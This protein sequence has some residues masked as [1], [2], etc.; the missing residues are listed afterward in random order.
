MDSIG[1]RLLEKPDA[2][3]W[4]VVPGIVIVDKK[5]KRKSAPLRIFLI[6]TATVL[7][8][9]GCDQ[10]NDLPG[11]EITPSVEGSTAQPGIETTPVGTGAIPIT[12]LGGNL[13]QGF[14]GG[15]YPGGSN[16]M[17]PQHAQAG[18]DRAGRVQP[19]TAAG[20]PS[21]DGKY[22]LLSI[23]MANAAEEFCGRTPT[24][25]QPWSFAGLAAQSSE[26]NHEQLVIVN[27]AIYGGSAAQWNAPA[28]KSYDRVRDEALAPLGL[29]ERQVQVV[30][31]KTANNEPGSKPSIPDPQSDAQFLMTELGDIIR[32]LR[33]RYPNLQQVFISSRI[34]GGYTS[35]E[36]NPEPYAYESGFA[37]KWVIE[38][39]IQQMVDG[40][41]GEA[42]GNLNYNRIAPWIAWGPYLWTDG[43]NPRSDGLVWQPGDVEPDSV[44]P[45]QSG[46]RKVGTM[47]FQ[48]FSSSP[49]TTPWFL[50]N[51]PTTQPPTPTPVPQASEP[52]PTSAEAPVESPTP[53]AVVV[54]PTPPAAT[55]NDQTP[56]PL[57][58]MGNGT[59]MGFPGGLYPGGNA[60]PLAHAQFGL[61]QANLIQP[62]DTAGNPSP[63][64]K[65]VLLAVGMSNAAREFGVP[66]RQQNHTFVGQVF[67]N[68]AVDMENL[69]LINGARSGQDAPDWEQPNAYNYNWV[70]DTQLVPNGLSENQVQVI[71]LKQ[72]N[73]DAGTRPSLPS[74]EADAYVFMERMGNILRSLKIRYP[75]LRQVFIS[76]RVYGGYSTDSQNP[77]PYAYESGFA[78]KWL[79][80]AQ[81][82]QMANGGAVINSHAGDLNYETAA[83]WIAWGPYMWANGTIPRSD[84]LVWVPGDFGP[85][86][87]HPFIE[88]QRKVAE[89]LLAFFESSPLTRC[90]FLAEG[91]C[92]L[93]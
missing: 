62:L 29:N 74:P 7:I 24:D 70:R 65:Y 45:S 43:L 4:E 61:E 2:D 52:E 51:Q 30:W 92:Q 58:D 59:Y 73:G 63:D 5:L 86:G 38:S 60:M 18:L 49:F 6:L 35:N 21:P 82:E 50:G 3:F 36:V 27:G 33:V 85:D 37:V 89:M 90:W 54:T 64:G 8:L 41:R 40:D 91:V 44:R 15:L 17:P 93:P 13:Y 81:I 28:A 87:T 55:G 76:S 31:L 88:G 69:V 1:G 12:D 67:G 39:Q 20:N 66:G 53:A 48:F 19:L 46:E 34:Y 22:V 11:T 68:Q 25:C 14:E 83:P 75:N 72:A 56:I 32:A 78:V 80:Q 57:I 26:V 71:W 9:A 16:E 23:G 79:I 84:G 47:L 77:E 10:A 42:A